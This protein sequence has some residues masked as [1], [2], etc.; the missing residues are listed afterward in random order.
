MAASYFGGEVKETKR[1]KLGKLLGDE[2][3]QSA[4]HVGDAT[5]WQ[6][7]GF[8]AVHGPAGRRSLRGPVR[9]GVHKADV[10]DML[11]RLTKEELFRF[12]GTKLFRND[13]HRP[14]ATSCRKT[15]PRSIRR[16]PP[17]SVKK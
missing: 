12:D 13:V 5:Q 2:N 3:S 17:T 1:Y 10:S 6:G 8:P 7:G 11:R 4:A 9:E 16:S 15:R 14:P